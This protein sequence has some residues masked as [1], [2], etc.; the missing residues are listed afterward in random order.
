MTKVYVV[1]R[2]NYLNSWLKEV[3]CVCATRLYAE[4]QCSKM[5][6]MD[7]SKDWYVVEECALEGEDK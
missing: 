1:Y 7:Y 4:Q 6:K 2:R 5:R 3:I